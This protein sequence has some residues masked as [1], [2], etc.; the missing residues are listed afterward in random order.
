MVV[1][2]DKIPRYN[3]ENDE[4]MYQKTWGL[5]GSRKVQNNRRLRFT[6][7]FAA[8]NRCFFGRCAHEPLEQRRRV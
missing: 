1:L 4:K 6:S 5:V 3:F 2:K 8:I 7:S